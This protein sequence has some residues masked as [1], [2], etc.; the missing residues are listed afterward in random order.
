LTNAFTLAPRIDSD[1]LDVTDGAPRPVTEPDPSRY[2]TGMS[3]EAVAFSGQH[4][5]TA[6]SV[7]GISVAEAITESPPP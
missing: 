3:N 4:V 1:G 7:V 6:V 5:H 2:S